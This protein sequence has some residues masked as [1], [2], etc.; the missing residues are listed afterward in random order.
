[1]TDR[2]TLDELGVKYGT[3]KSSKHHNYLHTYSKYLEPLRY[4]PILLLEIGTGG[5]EFHNRGGESLRMWCEYF[6]DGRICS[7]DIHD[8]SGI[9]VPLNGM[10]ATGSEDDETFLSGLVKTIGK[11]NVIINDASHIAPLIVRNFEILFPHLKSGGIFV[12]EDLHCSFY[13]EI[14]TDGYNYQGKRNS[15]NLDDNIPTNMLYNLC[16]QLIV[17]LGK[18]IESIHFYKGTVIILKK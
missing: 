3:D 12:I 7:V 16:N 15:K 4:K 8:K 13:E 10:L 18:E 6:T 5:Y 11:P 1:M 17:G 2:P 9:K 14:A